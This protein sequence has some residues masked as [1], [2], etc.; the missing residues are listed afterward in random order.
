MAEWQTGRQSLAPAGDPQQ[1]DPRALSPS[2]SS[3]AAPSSVFWWAWRR[4][5]AWFITFKMNVRSWSNRWHR[6]SLT[7]ALPDVKALLAT[8]P[9]ERFG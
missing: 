6:C 4:L 1:P 8:S 5:T 2:R 3:Q 9:P 7:A